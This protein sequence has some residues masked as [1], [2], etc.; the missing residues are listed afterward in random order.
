MRL[1]P[2]LEPGRACQEHHFYA[3]M[4]ALG[5]GGPIYTYPILQHTETMHL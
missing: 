5:E 2:N 4:R 1:S 3:N